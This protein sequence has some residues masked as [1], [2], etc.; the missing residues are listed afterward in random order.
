MSEL[1]DKARKG[2]LSALALV[3]VARQMENGDP[4]G[5]PVAPGAWDEALE[6][7]S[8]DAADTL[9]AVRTAQ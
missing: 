5:K 9:A 2:A 1:K 6:T 3:A 8:A 7:A 4:E